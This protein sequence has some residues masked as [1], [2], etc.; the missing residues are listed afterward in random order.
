MAIPAPIYL[1]AYRYGG[2][3]ESRRAVREGR[4]VF[5]PQFNQANFLRRTSSWPGLL[6]YGQVGSTV[7]PTHYGATGIAYHV[8]I[9]QKLR[10]CHKFLGGGKFQIDATLSESVFNPSLFTTKHKYQISK[11][12]RLHLYYSLATLLL[13]VSKG[14]SLT[15]L[16]VF[17]KNSGP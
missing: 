17:Q 7:R 10:N 16:D 11:Q 1:T 2:Y 15:S 5:H 12:H 3:G 8:T 6:W 9:L 4:G 13:L 14:P